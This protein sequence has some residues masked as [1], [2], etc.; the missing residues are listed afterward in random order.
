G[1]SSGVG[2]I[3]QVGVSD[4]EV[5]PLHDLEGVDEVESLGWYKW[6]YNGVDYN[7]GDGRYGRDGEDA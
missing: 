7:V 3:R 1:E 5:L 2:Y 4:M 6:G